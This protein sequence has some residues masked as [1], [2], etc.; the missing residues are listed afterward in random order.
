MIITIERYE[1]YYKIYGNC[2]KRLD[3][4][5][6]CFKVK[7]VKKY[8]VLPF[9]NLKK[10]LS[11]LRKNNLSFHIKNSYVENQKLE[12]DHCDNPVCNYKDEE[13]SNISYALDK[14][15]GYHYNDINTPNCII[16]IFTFFYICILAYIAYIKNTSM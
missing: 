1:G 16:K 5:L 10:F 2:L 11:F 4:E 12:N 15:Y 8:Y 14:Y 13:Q 9:Y 3:T 6:S 7:K